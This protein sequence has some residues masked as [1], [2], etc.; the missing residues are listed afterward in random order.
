MEL[1]SS[2]F[3]VSGHSGVAK[4]AYKTTGLGFVLYR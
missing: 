3:D 4:R 2:N 1:D